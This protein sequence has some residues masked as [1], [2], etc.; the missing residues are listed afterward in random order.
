MV[1]WVSSL[2][3]LL[4]PDTNTTKENGKQYKRLIF[5][6]CH[7]HII[8]ES[9]LP[10]RYLTIPVWLDD[11]FSKRG[12]R[13]GD[14]AYI[15]NAWRAAVKNEIAGCS[16]KL[17]VQ[18]THKKYRTPIRN[19][20]DIIHRILQAHNYINRKMS[21]NLEEVPDA[22]REITAA[23]SSSSTFTATGLVSP[24]AYATS[25]TTTTGPP[26]EAEAD[27]KRS[28]SPAKSSSPCRPRLGSNS[29]ILPNFTKKDTSPNHPHQNQ[30]EADFSLPLTTPQVDSYAISRVEQARQRVK[31]SFLNS[32]LLNTTTTTTTSSIHSV[33]YIFPRF[34]K[35]ELVLGEVLGSGGFGTVLE[36]R[37]FRLLLE[38]QEEDHDDNVQHNDATAAS[39]HTNNNTKTK[40]KAEK[41]R[42]SRIKCRSFDESELKQQQ[43]QQQQQPR[44]KKR[45][46]QISRNF[47]LQAWRNSESGEEGNDA[48]SPEEM[49]RYK[50]QYSSSSS[51]H[52]LDAKAA[53]GGGD[54]NEYGD[55][56]GDDQYHHPMDCLVDNVCPGG[57]ST[58]LE[59]LEER[60]TLEERPSSCSQFGMYEAVLSHDTENNNDTGG[61]DDDDNDD[62]NTTTSTPGSQQQ[63]QQQSQRKRR[64]VFFQ[65]NQQQQ[66]KQFISE[67]ATTQ[68]GESRYVIKIIQPDIVQNE[69]KKFL[70]AAMDMATETKFLSVLSHPNILQMRAVG[71]GDMFS[72]DYFLVLDRLYDTLLDRI[73]GSWRVTADHLENDFFVWNRAKKGKMLWAERMGVMRDIA[74]A[75]AYIHDL[76]IIYRDI[77][78]VFIFICVCFEMNAFIYIISIVFNGGFV[79]NIILND[80]KLTF[81]PSCTRFTKKP[82]NIGFDIKGVVKLFDFGLAKEV[83]KE[84]ESP[85]GTYKLTA[86]TGSLRY[87]APEVGN[88]WPYN[89]LADSYSFGIMLWEVTSLDRP[90]SMYTPNEMRDIVM[91]WGERPK[92][93]D[94]WPERVKQLM[95]TAWDSSFR[96]RPT[97][98]AFRDAL[99]KEVTEAV[100]LHV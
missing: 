19:K 95:T 29:S 88:K 13:S 89:F 35:S 73:E 87:M 63:Q 82:E 71:Q 70:Q 96:K 16:Y 86:D 64:I 90:F 41:K 23:V 10:P 47:S 60:P 68:S 75:L 94:V 52:K 14:F 54:G 100:Q 18:G 51:L 33:E 22:G 50:S 77:V 3:E 80:T 76:G 12:E 28:S 74:G 81:S 83:R 38:T 11:H 2:E 56:C 32:P 72:P 49:E 15:I 62:G 20:A 4:T 79:L 34:D 17:C 1:R 9:L 57:F 69:F 61:D 78:S 45:V 36:I 98:E 31:Q 93:K 43:Q 67:N 8:I 53:R 44:Q 85:N 40:Q 99:E 7:F 46:R 91:K 42:P 84:D 65:P 21:P 58:E 30:T 25:A 97:M 6:P 27:N 39:L 66:D 24:F 48:I 55:E 59:K 37:G 26:D 5:L 92:V